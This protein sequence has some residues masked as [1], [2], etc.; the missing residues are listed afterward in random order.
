MSQIMCCDWL[1]EW[2][3]W[4]YVAGTGLP[5]VSRKK[6]FPESHINPLLTK[7]VRSRWLHIGQVLFCGFMDL[8]S[9]SVDKHAK[10]NLSN[11]QPSS[12]HTWSV[13]HIMLSLILPSI[14]YHTSYGLRA[15]RSEFCRFILAML[16][17]SLLL[18]AFE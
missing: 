1:P 11:I 17:I 15:I 2:A 14:S 6:N 8:D 12:P 5:A 3:R 7:L 18:C 9:V 4:S 10:K 13:T 16:H